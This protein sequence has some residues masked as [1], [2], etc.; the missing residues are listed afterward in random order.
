MRFQFRRSL[1]TDSFLCTAPLLTNPRRAV[2]VLDVRG[3]PV[4]R[5]HPC[6][7]FFSVSVLTRLFSIT[8]ILL[9]LLPST[10]LPGVASYSPHLPNPF[11]RRSSSADLL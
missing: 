6:P 4:A 1:V 9:F 8:F 10:L 2:Y 3:M 5:P 7:F 11:S